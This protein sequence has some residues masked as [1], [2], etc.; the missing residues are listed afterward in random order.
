MPGVSIRGLICCRT[1]LT[2]HSQCSRACGIEKVSSA[3]TKAGPIDSPDLHK[4]IEGGSLYDGTI[5]QSR[6]GGSSVVL[7]LGGGRRRGGTEG[8]S[9]GSSLSG[10][11][12]R[13]SGKSGRSE[14]LER[15]LK[16]LKNQ[17]E[18]EDNERARADGQR[19]NAS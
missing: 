1:M 10:S 17:E 2:S 13:Q 12:E 9:D 18:K 14:H 15:L 16:R 19:A 8:L 7:G 4:S 3:K 6:V 11:S 5:F